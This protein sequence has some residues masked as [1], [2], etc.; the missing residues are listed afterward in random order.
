MAGVEVD[1]VE[2]MKAIVGQEIGP[3]DSQTVTC[4]P[5]RSQ[6]RACSL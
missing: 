3:S 1:G 2:G 5:E 4:A 6:T